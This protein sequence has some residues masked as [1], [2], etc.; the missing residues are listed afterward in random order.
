MNTPKTEPNKKVFLKLMFALVFVAAAAGFVFAQYKKSRPVIDKKTPV[1]ESSPAGNAQK[2]AGEFGGMPSSEE[3]KKMRES[4][5]KELNL[6]AEQNAK[7]QEIVKKYGDKDDMESFR[8]RLSEMREILTPEQREKAQKA[9]RGQIMSR[10][11]D[12]IK[13]LPPDQQEKFKEKFDKRFEERR[14]SIEQEANKPA[15][16]TKPERKETAL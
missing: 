6:T 13:V 15:N 7:M 5:F 12:R 4:I 16:N 3:R 10:M 11:Q 9:M 1:S 14:K 2:L 8:G